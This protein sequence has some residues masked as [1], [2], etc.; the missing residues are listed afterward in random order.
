MIRPTT[1]NAP[2]WRTLTFH[3]VDAGDVVEYGAR[4][5]FAHEHC[6][7]D[8]PNAIDNRRGLGVP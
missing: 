6:Q 4:S 1:T 5:S 7:D 3:Q 8:G 2:S